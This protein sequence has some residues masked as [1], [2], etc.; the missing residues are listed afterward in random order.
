MYKEIVGQEHRTNGA[1][2]DQVKIRSGEQSGRRGIV[3]ELHL[4]HKFAYEIEDSG[5]A[6]FAG[7]R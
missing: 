4:R 7:I 6:L 3:R 2:G 1:V 5:R